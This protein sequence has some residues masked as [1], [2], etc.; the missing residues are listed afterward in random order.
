[1]ADKKKNIR[2]PECGST[3]IWLVGTTPTRSGP[4]QRCKCVNC[5][6]SFNAPE[7]KGKGKPRAKKGS[8]K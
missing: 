5:G 6:R 7:P 4:K 3:R 8:K 2:C 1:M